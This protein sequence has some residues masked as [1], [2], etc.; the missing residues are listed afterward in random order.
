MTPLT[1]LV[2]HD[3]IAFDLDGVLL[4]GY[5]T[6]PDVYRRATVEA[7]ADFDV[8]VSDPPDNL[9]DPDDTARV[10]RSCEE[11][12]I[13]PEPYWGYREHASTVREN[14]RIRAGERDPYPDVDALETLAERAQLAVVSN[15]R[16]GTV[17]FVCER[18]EWGKY[19]N[20]AYGRAP[21]LAGY[22]RMKPDPHYLATA[23]ET[24][25]VEPADALFVG[26][27]LSDIETADRLGTDSALLV[28]DGD[29]PDGDEDPTFVIES[30]SDL[31]SIE[32]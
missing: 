14:D 30:L 20:A 32:T 16:H 13:P 6:P 15:N 28:R 24:L 21:T 18:F 8:A 17:R 4:T 19:V 31:V 5:H 23:L 7:L 29:R 9:V 12:G 1:R 22:D 11:L 2:S 25:A 27:R 3:A 26:D 10:R